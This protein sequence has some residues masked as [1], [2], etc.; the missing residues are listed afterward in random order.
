MFQY[1]GQ[2]AALGAATMWSLSSF[3]FTSVAQKIGPLQ[4]NLERMMIA[5]LLLIITIVATGH[6]FFV[7]STQLYL[8]IISGFLGLVVGDSFLFKA[9]KEIGPRLSVLV[10]SSNPAIAAILAFF[11]LDEGLDILS[12]TGI[13]ITIAGITIVV[14]ERPH[15]TNKFRVTKLGVLSGFLAASGQAAGLIFAKIAN[16]ISP[17]H[18]LPATFIRII[19]AIVLLLALLLAFKRFKR[20]FTGFS[21]DKRYLKF[22]LT[23]SFIGPYLGITLSYIAVINTKVGIASTLM[24]TMPIIMLPLTRMI[25]KEKLT[26]IS[27]AGA[28]IAV[29]GIALLFLH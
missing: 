29:G 23:G 21:K 28:F 11:V 27:V 15:A 10:M 18:Y 26:M 20:P 8:L 6:Y 5:A 3:M 16:N 7:S 13:I 14:L 12:I 19:A 25:N 9:Y 2:I 24:S 4:L 17:I 1:L 22:I